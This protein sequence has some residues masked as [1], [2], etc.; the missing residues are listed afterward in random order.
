MPEWL[1]ERGIGETRCALV[2]GR[3]IIEAH[4]LLDGQVRAGSVIAARLISAGTSGRNAVAVAEDGQEFLLPRGAP[5]AAE[6]AHDQDR[7]HPRS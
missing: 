4:I 7:G 2:D 3:R 6:G 5:G 1:I